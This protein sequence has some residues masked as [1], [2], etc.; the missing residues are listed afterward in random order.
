MR[1]QFVPRIVGVLLAFGSPATANLIANPGFEAGSPNLGPRPIGY[2]DWRGDRVAYVGGTLGITPFEGGRMLR[3][4]NGEYVPS[5]SVTS[6]YWQNVDLGG[7]AVDIA[8]GRVV[9]DA[10]AWFNRVAGD[11]QTDTEFQLILRAR[12]GSPSAVIE[13]GSVYAQLF[14]DGDPTTWQ[15]ARIS[16][17]LLPA[18]TTH[19]QLEL[20]AGENVFNDATNPEFDGHLADGVALSLA[21]VPE[22]TSLALGTIGLATLLGVSLRGR[23]RRRQAGG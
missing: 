6:Q 15:V 1:H 16:G 14:A 13:L 10:A 7:F 18:G 4:I 22:P 23:L 2:G 21:V 9:I 3:F 5:R 20:N 11:A 8:A 12:G 17:Y 19:L